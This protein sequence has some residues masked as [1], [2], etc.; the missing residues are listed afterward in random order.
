MQNTLGTDR[1]NASNTGAV[2]HDYFSS[3]QLRLREISG[4]L[5]LLLYPSLWNETHS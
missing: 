4:L 5:A 1:T 2:T 3:C